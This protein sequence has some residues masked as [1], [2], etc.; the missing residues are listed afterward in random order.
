V[1]A[2][3]FRSGIETVKVTWNFA[4][5]WSYMIGGP[6]SFWAKLMSW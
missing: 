2:Y 6:P 1:L 5:W 4:S 3:K